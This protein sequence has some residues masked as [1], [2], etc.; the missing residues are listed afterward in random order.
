MKKASRIVPPRFRELRLRFLSVSVIIFSLIL[1]IFQ[2]L[3]YFDRQGIIFLPDSVASNIARISVVIAALFITS[4]I[5]RFT[6]RKVFSLFDEPEERI[7][8]SKI[9]GWTLYG[10]GI[11]FIL[12]YLGVS[13][14]NITIFIGLLATGLAFAI[15]DVLLS[16]FGWI[17][18][19]RKKPFHIGDF[20]RIG[21]DEG[22]VLHIGTFYVWLDK[23]PELPEDY[24]KVPN[25]LFLEK[26]IA[27]LGTTVFHDEIRIQL[28]KMP[29]NNK[30]LIEE[31]IKTVKEITRKDARVE[32]WI[33]IQ[34]DKLV[35]LI[36]FLTGFHERQNLRS[37]V[38]SRTFMLFGDNIIIPRA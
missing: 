9:Y 32:A 13:L 28:Y 2:S 33:D 37:E 23:T 29:E 14:G 27:N 3:L 20:I 36:S 4:L 34:N 6:I 7:F 8:Y 35:L 16:F 26:S 5:L 31:L 25:R 18:L 17:I 24:T 15:R 12:H 10:L 1:I 38:I 30:E 21:E 11:F 19:L 22:K